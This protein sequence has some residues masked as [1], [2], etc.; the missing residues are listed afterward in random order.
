MATLYIVKRDGVETARTYVQSEALSLASDYV[1]G[2][3]TLQFDTKAESVTIEQVK[4]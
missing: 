3:M 1:K 2:N 4:G